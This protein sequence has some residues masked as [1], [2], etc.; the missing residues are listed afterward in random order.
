MSMLHQGVD[1]GLGVFAVHLGHHYVTC[2]PF[3]QSD[4]LAVVGTEDQIT[5]PVTRHGSILRRWWALADRDRVADPAV[6]LCLLRVTAR[7]TH[8]PRSPKVLQQL[9]F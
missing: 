8:C 2:L 4:D 5:F 9:L 6:I 1:Y 7:A 3:H